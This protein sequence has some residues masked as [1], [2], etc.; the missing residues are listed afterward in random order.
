MVSA[1]HSSTILPSETRSMTMIGMTKSLP[2]GAT[3]NTVP[4]SWMAHC[5]AAYHH[6]AVGCLVLDAVADV[7]EAGVL[8]G[9]TL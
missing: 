8:L 2:V 7:R 1:L 3:P 4:R 5:D 9:G 6:V